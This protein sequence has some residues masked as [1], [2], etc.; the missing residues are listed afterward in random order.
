MI[1][2]CNFIVDFEKKSK[3]QVAFQNLILKI[4]LHLLQFNIYT[5]IYYRNKKTILIQLINK[6]IIFKKIMI[7]TNLVEI[8]K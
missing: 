4:N 1:K 5:H 2:S 7:V 6:I 3:E 8:S